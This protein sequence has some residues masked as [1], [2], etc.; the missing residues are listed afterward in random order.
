MAG[1]KGG[2]ARG[3]PLALELLMADHRAVEELFDKF[4]QEKDGDEATRRDIAQ[5][6]CNELA[7]HAQVE[8]EL[9]YTWLRENLDEDDM[10]MVE[11]AQVEHNT[12]KDLIAQLEGATE[13]DEQ[14]NAKVKVLGEYTRHHV[15]EE[16]NEMFPKVRDMQEELDELGQEIAAR[17]DELKEELGM[18]AADSDETEE[19]GEETPASAR[20]SRGREGTHRGTR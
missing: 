4:E 1:T 9:L 14:Y 7:V 5:R 15:N 13:I 3:Q 12:A 17:K 11:E 19:E 16:E 2:I 6:I 18:D 10:E 20:S 8:E